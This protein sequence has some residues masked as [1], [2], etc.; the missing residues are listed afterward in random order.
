MHIK[1][2][3]EYKGNNFK[4]LEGDFRNAVDDLIESIGDKRKLYKIA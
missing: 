1:D 4:D 3:I 2:D